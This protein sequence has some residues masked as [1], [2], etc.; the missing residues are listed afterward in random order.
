MTCWVSFAKGIHAPLRRLQ[1]AGVLR[2]VLWWQMA[3]VGKGLC[4]KEGL[5]CRL[6][7][8]S[9]G[10]ERID[11]YLNTVLKQRSDLIALCQRLHG[12]V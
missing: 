9:C 2:A 3:L 1:F 5:L 6:Q 7:M 4:K 10:P 12:S 8:V 11:H